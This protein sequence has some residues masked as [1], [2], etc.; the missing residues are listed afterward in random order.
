M[1][2]LGNTVGKWPTGPDRSALSNEEYSVNVR[3]S[4]EHPTLVRRYAMASEEH[5]ALRVPKVTVSWVLLY[6]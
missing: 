3:D 1:G 6:F 5:K 2:C 4:L